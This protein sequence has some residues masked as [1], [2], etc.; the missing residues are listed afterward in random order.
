MIAICYLS[1]ENIL[2]MMRYASLFETKRARC[3]YILKVLI[4]MLLFF[5]VFC[6]FD[7]LHCF[8]PLFFVSTR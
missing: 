7:S 1:L 3:A 5:F 4:F 8:Y 6:Y 2:V